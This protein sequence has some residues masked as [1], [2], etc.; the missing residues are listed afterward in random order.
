MR[1]P[2]KTQFNGKAARYLAVSS[3]ALTLCLLSLMLFRGVLSLLQ[4]LII[5]ILIVLLA[6]SQ[7]WIYTFA[8][9]L[10]LL[11]LTLVFFPTQVVFMAVYF[12]MA[13]FLWGLVSLMKSKSRKRWLLFIP[14]VILNSLLLFFGLRMTDFVFQIPLHAMMLRLSGDDS[15]RYAA[16]MSLEAAFIS[17]LHLLVIFFVRRR[18]TKITERIVD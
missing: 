1:Q 7:P 9:G 15:L 17:G 3:L 2:A 4:A 18:Q 10:S 5:P 8:A 12:M 16:I 14:Y 11:V 13:I 6:A